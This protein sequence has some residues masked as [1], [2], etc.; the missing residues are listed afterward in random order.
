MRVVFR[1]ALFITMLSL[2]ACVSYLN[3]D[4]GILSF[5]RG[6]YREAFILLKPEAAKGAVDAQYAIGFMYYYGLG[7]TED[8]TEA[9]LWI[10]RAATAGLPA[11]VSARDILS[12]CHAISCHDA[13]ELCRD[14]YPSSRPLFCGKAK[15]ICPYNCPILNP[16]YTGR[17]RRPYR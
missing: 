17:T 4:E 12:T 2:T 6:D 13:E 8:R 10:N 5:K 9:W 3:L 16:I 11:A 1:L 7:V 15:L 14:P